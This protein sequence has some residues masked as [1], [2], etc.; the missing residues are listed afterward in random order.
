MARAVLR[1][2]ALDQIHQRLRYENS[3]DMRISLRPGISMPRPAR[4][5]WRMDS[6]EPA[7]AV[8]NN[9]YISDIHL[10]LTTD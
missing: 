7:R 5:D 8:F 1:P 3:P 9:E 2:T 6:Q 4:G 10:D